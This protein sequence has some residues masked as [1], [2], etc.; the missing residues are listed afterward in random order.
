[1]CV[2]GFVKSGTQSKTFIVV[3]IMIFLIDRL[4]HSGWTAPQT[5]QLPCGVNNL[6]EVS[7]HPEDVSFAP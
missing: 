5:N 6:P 2:G 7:E 1:M 3:I 4:I